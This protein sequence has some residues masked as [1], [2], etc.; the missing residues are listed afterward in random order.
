[1]KTVLRVTNENELLKD[2]VKRPKTELEAAKKPVRGFHGDIL[3]Y[4][5][6]TLCGIKRS[7][8]P[9]SFWIKKSRRLWHSMISMSS[10]SASILPNVK[11]NKY[12][13]S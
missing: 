10:G 13:P 8:S 5:V 6:V 3:M 12:F 11:A 4:S 1:M 7:H 9:L 2:D